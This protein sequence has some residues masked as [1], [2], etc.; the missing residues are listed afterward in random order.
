MNAM[1]EYF[2]SEEW[3]KLVL[4]LLHTLWQGGIIAIGLQFV[5]KRL[6]AN[7]TNKRYLFSIGAL[8]SVAIAGLITASVLDTPLV[9][10]AVRQTGN[11]RTEAAMGQTKHFDIETG[12]AA[13]IASANPNTT[14]VAP[15][16]LQP[17][18]TNSQEPIYRAW[19]AWG[20]ILWIAGFVLMSIRLVVQ[21]LDLRNFTRR[22]LPVNER[23]IQETVGRL[24]KIMGVKRTIRMM[25]GDHIVNPSIH[26]ILAPV[27]LLPPAL[28]L[29]MPVE[30]LEAILAHELG[31]I[32]RH[33]YVVNL[34][35]QL[36]E[37][38][39][40]FNPAVW[41]INRQIRIER[42]A[43]CDQLA[44]EATGRPEAYAWSLTHWAEKQREASLALAP[45]F[46]ALRNSGGPLERLR[47]LL[48]PNYRPAVRL[49]WHT[50]F[51]LLLIS[52]V[53]FL[54]I[55]Q[56]TYMAVGY[57]AEL[58]SPQQRIEKLVEI[59][60]THG[61]GS[62]SSAQA[63][64]ITRISGIISKPDGTLFNDE[65]QVT[66]YSKNFN[67][68]TIS[69]V[70]TVKGGFEYGVYPGTVY[71]CA[72]SK[73][74][75]PAFAGPV[76][77]ISGETNKMFQFTLTNG[78]SSKVLLAD[79]L[80]TESN[81]GI[82]GAEV[83]FCYTH[84]SDDITRHTGVTGPDGT[85]EYDHLSRAPLT[86]KITA[87]GYQ[88]DEMKEIVLRPDTVL[89]YNLS[90][91]KKTTG[92][93][94][95]RE[96][97]HPVSNA[98][99]RLMARS[100]RFNNS[101][102]NFE[103]SPVLA[104]SDANGQFELTTLSS[105]ANYELGVQVDGFAPCIIHDVDAG[106]NLE[107]KL[108]PAIRIQGKIIG[109]SSH[110]SN[111]R[112]EI[113][114]ESTMQLSKLS[115][116]TWS[117]KY[118]VAYR[119]GVGYF[120]ITNALPGKSAIVLGTYR[121]ELNIDKSIDNLLIDLNA[122]DDAN[123]EETNDPTKWAD[124]EIK[125]VVPAGSPL[126]SGSFNCG[127]WS[128]KTHQGNF[129]KAFFTNGQ[130]RLKIPVPGGISL[131]SALFRTYW[132]EKTNLSLK[133]SGSAVFN[134]K[135]I[136]AGTIYGKVV[137]VDGSDIGG[138]MV[139]VLEVKSSPLKSETTLLGIEP[140]SSSSPDDGPTLFAA[141]P[142]P[143]GGKYIIL[144]HVDC[145]YIGSEPILLTEK[146]PIQEITLKKVKGVTVRGR[147]LDPSGNPVTNAEVSFGFTSESSHSFGSQPVLTSINGD[148]AF[149]KVNPEAPGSYS[150]TVGHA[151]GLQPKTQKVNF[152]KEQLLIKLEKGLNLKGVVVD[153]ASGVPISKARVCAVP[154]ST[155][156]SSGNG[157]IPRYAT[158]DVNGTFEFT[159]LSAGSFNLLVY[160]TELISPKNTPVRG[161]Q[162]NVIKIRVKPYDWSSLMPK[163][164][165]K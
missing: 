59:D 63:T 141:Q 38:V 150:V 67:N 102:G 58:L 17:M 30:H 75:A 13:A 10:K 131:E 100:G 164:Q 2:A 24:Q 149:D 160:E 116:Q 107:V 29:G 163:L 155:Y 127:Y 26:G 33:D 18:K 77:I 81:K 41:W 72:I 70:R 137:D 115:S 130:S 52:G 92:V 139:G 46:G 43:C 51:G 60:K 8:A 71:V 109:V 12:N 55:F 1:I 105:Q 14:P 120:E 34:I 84:P 159:D 124:V 140:K 151:K 117:K 15:P 96:T 45:A 53:L 25:T 87:K 134:I 95:A 136:P 76:V 27:L 129:I 165:I 73:G 121:K 4:V 111:T 161:G 126:P 119:D 154:D 42:E 89:T 113:E 39:L 83:E 146:N 118:K 110:L 40:F 44:V 62:R 69:Q 85:I 162:T 82:S 122:N 94:V 106:K 158:T 74:Y 86:L 32:R 153:D 21:W 143:L 36:V 135:A 9:S 97:G 138:M 54:G 148:F 16:S 11:V 20:A 156:N 48:I 31:H 23:V 90:P 22:C 133:T 19:L 157:W 88:Y 108:D 5:L 56:G 66:L 79:G 64:Q 35:Q 7:R 123:P 78:Y 93:I 68:S 80:K 65:V 104:V 128:D 49:P 3:S 147:V 145:Q 112:R 99:V 125:M 28:V 6:P 57:A 142:L 114:L 152:R 50:L 103:Y 61:R 47:R 98:E 144:A 101:W 37:T 91:S 132:I